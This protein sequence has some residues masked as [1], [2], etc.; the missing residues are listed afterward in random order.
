MLYFLNQIIHKRKICIFFFLHSSFFIFLFSFFFFHSYSQPIKGKAVEI[1]PDK[2]ETPLFGANVY[3]SGT[4]TGTTTDQ[5]GNFEI[6]PVVFPASLV[7][8]FVGYKNDTLFF[9]HPPES[10][11]KSI[12][13]STVELKTI[14]VEAHQQTTHISTI[15]PIN[16]EKITQGELK[17]AACCNLSESFETNATVD[18]TYTDAVSGAKKIQ[19]LGLTGAYS[20]IMFENF[21]LIRGLS[22]NYG[23]GY[24]PGTWIKAIS[25][26]KG[27]GSV[28][29]GYESISGQLC[30]DFLQ[31]DEAEKF[32]VNV[33]A[34]HQQR[35]E[36][37]IHTAKKFNDKWSSIILLHGNDQ[38]MKQD[39]NKD[40][41][42]DM[43]LKTQF[44]AM[45]R[46]KYQG[47]KLISQFG[48]RAMQEDRQGGQISFDYNRD[49]GTTNSYGMGIS[50]RQLDVFA[51]NGLLF[52]DKPYKS[53]GFI[54][55]GR[56]HRL[57]SFYG[58]R[59]YEGE[60]K[61]LYANVIYQGII[62]S[63]LHTFKT[64]A[65]YMLDYYDEI[66]S[67]SS[68]KD[69]S[70]NRTESVP[71]VFGEY[72]YNDEEKYSAV[73]GIRSDLHNLYG[74]FLSPRLHLKYNFLPLSAIRFSAGRGYR[75]PN[76]FVENSTVL[77]SSRQVIVE[78]N[79]RPEI[80]WNGGVSITHKFKIA[81]KDAL[82]NTDFFR[83]EFENQV[84]VDLENAREVRFYNLN[85]KSFSNSLQVDFSFEPL[86]KLDVKTSYKWY[87]VQTNFHSGLKQKPLVPKNRA[88]FNIAYTTKYDKW[89]FDAT[90]QW[91]GVS[92][93]PDTSINPEAY[94]LKTKSGNY[95]IVN[96]Q[97]TRNFLLWE[98][99][100][101]AENLLHYIQP[102]AILAAD[103]PFGNNFDASL[104]WGPISGRTIYAGARF[105]IK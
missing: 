54:T 75:R 67:A 100:L 10:T 103:A 14:E 85:G 71:G 46:W 16:V 91:Y 8:S 99:Y 102:N 35:F 40:L 18:V 78:Q 94:Q 19:M 47:E 76:I 6:A 25:V 51:K 42:L 92:R 81:E 90:V 59:K 83:T 24:I 66:Y 15:N 41:F 60:Q 23:F 80:A 88:L 11:V 95:Y 70:F 89:K 62:S 77:A 63:T 97:I 69:S 4:T 93:I 20:Q 74:V 56:I 29:N 104:I 38:E 2:K 13:Q 86:K 96:S 65:S 72:T 1:N 50:D 22:S 57:N 101:G 49:F 33:Y 98:I 3:W 9:H 30:L 32:F 7:I 28:I 64:G 31:P 58:L 36:L 105:S 17:K 53:I 43:P 26:I 84:V 73:I 37:N 27:S 82:L 55:S 44:T 48:V 12:L 21:P 52:P 68:A 79:V 39:L 34:N 87:D 5:D 61:N 45:N